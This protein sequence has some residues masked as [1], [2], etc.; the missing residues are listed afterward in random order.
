MLKL[1][2]PSVFNGKSAEGVDS[3]ANFT[4]HSEI[5]SDGGLLCSVVNNYA[6]VMI[7]LK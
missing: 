6:S 3:H 1:P 2:L 4:L 5:V 7:R